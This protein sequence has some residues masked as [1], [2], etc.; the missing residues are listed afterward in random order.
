M[1]NTYIYGK[2]V[3][4][5]DN[6]IANFNGDNDDYSDDDE[7]ANLA[8][9]ISPPWIPPP[10]LLQVGLD[11]LYQPSM[12]YQDLFISAGAG[13]GKRRNKKKRPNRRNKSK[14]NK[15]KRINVKK[16]KKYKMG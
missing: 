1:N 14:K 3:A 4:Y 16:Y 6:V 11:E 15:S 13:G 12:P 2:C 8:P 10:P 9:V 7:L 5:L